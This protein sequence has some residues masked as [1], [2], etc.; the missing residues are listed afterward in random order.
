[1]NKHTASMSMEEA[2]RLTELGGRERPPFDMGLPQWRAPV[3]VTRV[4]CWW[5]REFHSPAEVLTCMALPRKSATATNGTESTSIVP[6][7]GPLSQYAEL[8]AFL[9]ATSYPDGAKRRTGRL[10]LSCDVDLL[11]LSLVDEETS[12]YAFLNGRDL[13]S[14]LEEAELRLADGSLSFKPSRYNGKGKR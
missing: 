12:Q 13:T 6:T 3:V 5:C 1:M 10:S 14:L 9:T 11:G 2:V 4:L 8:W 7:P